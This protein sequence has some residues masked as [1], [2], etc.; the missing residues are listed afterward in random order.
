MA[1]PR[2]RRNGMYRQ[3][4]K[5]EGQRNGTHTRPKSRAQGE[6][7]GQAKLAARMVRA[8]RIL[9]RTGWYFSEIAAHLAVS[10]STIRRAVQRET[11]RH[12]L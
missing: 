7:N 3:G 1:G 8:A 5:I 4:W 11:W 9:R 6:R 2:G 10:E 12:V